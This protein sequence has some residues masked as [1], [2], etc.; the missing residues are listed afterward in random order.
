M[1]AEV[2]VPEVGESISEGLLA[3]WNKTNGSSVQI[4]EPLFELETDKVTL[5]VPAQTGG[6]L[7]ILIPEGATVKIGQTV[8][9]I[10][11]A[12]AVPKPAAPSPAPQVTPGEA[13]PAAPKPAAPLPP[14]PEP[15]AAE[16]APSPA[17]PEQA[18]SEPTGQAAAPAERPA[19]PSPAAGGSPRET[20]SRMSP[21]RLRIAQRLVQAQQ[22]AA[23]LTTFNEAD[24]SAVLAVRSQYQEEFQKKHGVRLG[25]M[26]F[27]V[28][29]AVEALRSVPEMNARIEGE[30]LVQQH[31]YDLG[32]AVNTEQGLMVPVLRDA[33]RLSF[34]GIEQQ[35]AELARKA[36]ERKVTLDE[37]LGGCFTISNGGVFGSLL[38]TP[39]LNPP[40]AGI[41]GLHR[42][43]KRP[44]AVG[45]QIVIRPMMYLALSYD[46][47]IVDGA[48]AVAFLK[49]IVECVEDPQRMLVA[50]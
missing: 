9:H 36:R 23:I 48:R 42:I 16:E 13:P 38:S 37:L 3:V 32:V 39:L 12:A 35:I 7:V 29:A 31:Y 2:K 14:S 40:Q 28:K 4:G 49:R 5:T 41:L 1:L 18:R 46:H 45:D 33:D 21:L 11:T 25:F 8:A 19:D 30:E 50:V 17:T 43:Q 22:T 10:D 47:R 20:R 27:F 24:L 26:S 44:V 15:A 34:A 6:R